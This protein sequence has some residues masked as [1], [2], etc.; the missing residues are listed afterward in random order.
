MNPAI[1]L[2]FALLS[3]IITIASIALTILVFIDD[4]YP[5]SYLKRDI[6]EVIL[7]IIITCLLWSIL[8]YQL[9]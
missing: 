2:F 9:H 5:I 8:F 7:F 1:T 3:T 6:I 4:N